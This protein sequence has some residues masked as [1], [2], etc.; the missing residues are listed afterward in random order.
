MQ[1]PAQLKAPALP[2]PTTDTRRSDRR[3]AIAMT[4][5]PLLAAS[6]SCF[7]QV[8]TPALETVVISGTRTPEPAAESGSAVTIVTAEELEAKQIRLVSDALRAVPG[9]AVNRSG[10]AGTFTQ[11]RLRGAEANHT[12][13]LIDGMKIN[14]PFSSEVDFA[15]L[16]SAQIDRI[17]V[18][19]GPQSVLYGSE[20][21]GGV[22]NI[23]TKRGMAGTQAEASLEAGSFATVNGAA[24]LRGAT[25]RFN[26][27]LSLNALRTNGTNVSRFGSEN[28]GYRNQTVLGSAR[29]KPTSDFSLDATVRWRDSR[30]QSDP[31]DF[32][33]PPGPTY[34]LVVDG[35]RQT[36]SKQLDARLR[37]QLS[38]LDGRLEHQF[39]LARSKTEADSFTSGAFSSG[40]EGERT[41]LD[42]QGSLRFGGSTLP[43]V[44]T[45]AVEREKL[46]FVNRGPTP[47]SAQNQARDNNRT[48]LALEYRVRLP[49]QTAL[50]LSGRQD[51]NNLFEDA[52]TYRLTVAQPIGAVK[53]RAS[54]GTGVTNPTFFELFGFIPGSFDPN[55]N[56][57]PEKSFG[58]DVGADLS[59][60][61]GA[62]Q[63]SITLFDADLENE[64]SGSFNSTTFRS[65]SINL[66]GKSKRRGFELESRL[67]LSSEWSLGAA[68]T[69]SDSRQPDGQAEV[70]R[71]RHVAS[72]SV[73]YSLPSQRGGVTM[74]LDHNG[75]QQDLDFTSLS[76][77]RVELK[78]YTLF[79][80]A[81]RYAVTPLVD[82]TARIENAL[83]QQYEEVFSYRA[84]GRAI[85]LGLTARF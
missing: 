68:Y 1:T 71:P 26:Y 42:Y 47:A 39:G 81:A 21:I 34:G 49:S 20:A 50:T 46:E 9:I 28:D 27:A 2:R 6:A 41:L 67:K 73:S 35:D 58:F 19:R 53:L 29:W 44:L 32:S 3:T 31:Q 66:V 22:I 8:T 64:I 7:A 15:H 63:L 24:A 57:K 33:F 74:A 85:F 60:L 52:T 17:E 48:G 82:V 25:N 59:V 79:R 72:A 38:S 37:G 70:R 54:V 23:F 56:L 10:P 13:V 12:V 77:A 11:L 83:D 18:L 80:L 78:D 45:L 30:T 76:S 55:P 61:G 84:T 5:F 36:D 65:T 62:G 51:R 40:S 75:R 16:L 69:H 43:Q 4:A 14:D